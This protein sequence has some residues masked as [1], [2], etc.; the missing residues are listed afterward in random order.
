M[1]SLSHVLLLVPLV[2]PSLSQ[3]L[4]ILASRRDP[5]S[6]FQISAYAKAIFEMC[7]LIL[8]PM[9]EWVPLV[10]SYIYMSLQMF[11]VWLWG[12][13]YHESI[14]RLW[15]ILVTH[16]YSKWLCSTI[17]TWI[18]NFPS[19]FLAGRNSANNDCIAILPCRQCMSFKIDYPVNDL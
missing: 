3:N 1:L 8:T 14:F 9:V 7:V 4:L 2:L 17:N 11:A 13:P 6:M 5:I 16:H 10:S 19:S 12:V 18:Y 15:G